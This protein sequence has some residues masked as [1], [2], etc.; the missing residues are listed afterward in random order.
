MSK[1]NGKY[2]HYQIPPHLSLCLSSSKVTSVT[3]LNRV[4]IESKN[5][6]YPG[7]VLDVTYGRNTLKERVQCFNGSPSSADVINSR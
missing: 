7:D 2:M 5:I 3:K 6:Q 1:N 4:T